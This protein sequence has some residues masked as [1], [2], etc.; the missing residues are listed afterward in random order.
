M[1]SHSRRREAGTDS[2]AVLTSIEMPSAELRSRLHRVLEDTSRRLRAALRLEAMLCALLSLSLALGIGVALGAVRTSPDRILLAELLVLGLGLG[3]TALRYRSQR[4]RALES[5]VETADW[6]DRALAED[7]VQPEVSF[8]SAVE[9]D[10]DR[11]RYLESEVLID[12]AVARAAREASR[13]SPATLVRRRTRKL[14]VRLVYLVGAAA[15]VILVLGLAKPEGLLRG[16]TAYRSFSTLEEAFS[17]QAPEP[18]LGDIVLTYRYPA[19][20]ERAPRTVKSL[21]G[22]LRALPGTEVMIQ[23]HSQSPLAEA[24]LLLEQAGEAAE[25]ERNPFSIDGHSLQV[26]FVVTRSG[27]WKVRAKTHKGE[28]LEQRRGQ[29]VELEA[30]LPPEVKLDKPAE[31]S[32]QVNEKDTLSLAFEA[33]DDFGLGDVRLAWRV[34]GTARE[35]TTPLTSAARGRSLYRGEA[36]L[37]LSTLELKPGDRVAYSVEAL[38]NDTVN[39]PKVGGSQTK[40]LVVYSKEAHHREVL[41]LQEKALDELVHVLGDNLET[42]F[43][44]RD[45]SAYASMLEVSKRIIERARTTGA[46]MKGVAQAIRKDPPGKEAVATAFERARRELMNDARSK[47]RALRDAER[48]F[49]STR[50]VGTPETQRVRR[51]QAKMIDGLEKNVVYLADLLSDQRMI[52]AESLTKALREQQQELR[53]VLEDYKNAPSEEKRRLLEDAMREIRRRIQE[54]TQD[55]ARVKGSIPPD[56]VNPDALEGADSMNAMDRIQ[57]MVEEG[58]LE[59]AMSELE[60]MLKSTEQMIAELQ[61]GREELGSRE[62]SEVTEIAEQLW[63]ELEEVTNDQGELTKRNEQISDALRDRMKDRL[64]NPK[65]FIEKQLDR[66]AEAA[67]NVEKAAPGAQTPGGSESYENLLQRM[68]DTAQALKAEDFGAAKEMIEQALQNLRQVEEEGSR[69]L[70]QARRFG[71]W[72]GGEKEIGEALRELERAAPKLEAVEQDIDRLLPNPAELLSKN[73][74]KELDRLAERQRELEGRAQG[75]GQK[76]GQLR[77]L[78]PV[79]GEGT[80]ELLG[81]AQGAMKNAEQGLR[82][83]DSPGASGDQ[84]RAMDA[85]ESLKKQLEEMNQGGGGGGGGV[86]LP[87]GPGTGGEPGGESDGRR[88]NDQKVEIPKPEQFQAPAEFREDILD[89]AKKGTVESYRDAVRRYYEEIIK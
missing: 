89:A 15:F 33:E 48:F 38:D 88:F 37:D 80:Q 39:G 82:R 7:S 30:D 10:R 16:L 57:E 64:G 14:R 42:I 6:L 23:T 40:E 20:T 86:P 49:V 62:Y 4:R 13:L 8:R 81:E 28:R 9:L 58:N 45:D 73:E 31:D 76:L 43:G 44:P 70:E 35:G 3:L 84:R 87:F 25:P 27:R 36:K 1:R 34:L 47:E 11:G 68:A 29:A 56:F 46:L 53:K 24:T 60:S 52:D 78:L 41:A 54:I 67:K 21:T 77:E 55:L 85:L 79:M 63:K 2:V 72:F 19:Y 5:R 69:R 59:G 12:E 26:T 66:L 50:R 51:D 65:A 75:V 18:Q 22:D 74:R 83:G 32:L 71:D 61:E 17:P